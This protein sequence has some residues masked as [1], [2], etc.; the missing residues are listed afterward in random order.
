MCARVRVHVGQ[1]RTRRVRTSSSF[2]RRPLLFIARNVACA[3]IAFITCRRRFSAHTI[4]CLAAARAHGVSASPVTPAT[5]AN[6][7]LRGVQDYSIPSRPDPTPG[8]G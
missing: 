8:G 1:M 7:Y 3:P 6:A 5:H 2:L 4:Y